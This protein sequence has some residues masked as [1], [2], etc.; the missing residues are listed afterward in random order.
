MKATTL[1]SLQFIAIIVMIGTGSTIYRNNYSAIP[2]VIALLVFIRC[3]LY[4]EKHGK[5]LLMEYNREKMKE[6]LKGVKR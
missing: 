4:I 5:R 6:T 2:F 3:S 1:I